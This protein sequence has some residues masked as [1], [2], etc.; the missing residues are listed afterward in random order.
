MRNS[1]CGFK[2]PFSSPLNSWCR[3]GPGK[4]RLPFWELPHKKISQ[5]G[6]PRTRQERMPAGDKSFRSRPTNGFLLDELNRCDQGVIPP[7]PPP[8]PRPCLWAS[9]SS[10]ARSSRKRGRLLPKTLTFCLAIPGRG[11]LPFP[12]WSTAFQV[13]LAMASSIHFWSRLVVQ[14]G[15]N[16]NVRWPKRK[17]KPSATGYCEA[18][19]ERLWQQT[20][21]LPAGT[22]PRNFTGSKTRPGQRWRNGGMDALVRNGSIHREESICRTR[23]KRFV[24]GWHPFLAGARLPALADF[25]MR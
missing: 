2:T 23:T 22:W 18:K 8:L 17:W 14:R 16:L 13:P 7:F 15:V 21:A 24:P 5:R 9:K 12:F 6:K 19:S 25:F 10:S 20:P 11:W 4:R 1:D 3:S